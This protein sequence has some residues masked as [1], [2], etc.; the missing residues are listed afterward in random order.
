[1]RSNRNERNVLRSSKPTGGGAVTAGRGVGTLDDQWWTPAGATA[2]HLVHWALQAAEAEFPGRRSAVRTVD[3]HV[4]RPSAPA[5]FTWMAIPIS[6][7]SGH[8]VLTFLFDQG[9]PLAVG[10]VAYGVSLS[11][12]EVAGDLRPPAAL[13]RLAYRPMNHL[14]GAAPPVAHRFEHRPTLDTNGRSPRDG[15]DVVWVTPLDA[16]RLEGRQRLATIVDSWFPPIYMSE[17]RKHLGQQKDLRQPAPMVLSSAHVAFVAADASLSADDS[18]LLATEFTA[19]VNG[20]AF[21]RFEMWN[22]SGELLAIGQVIRRI[23]A[24]G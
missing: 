12:D 2:G 14:Q 3:L 6:V 7:R 11:S 1:M 20:H 9:G 8:D 21:E 23:T 13:P 5:E 16:G 10:T 19:A 24:M 15:W 17:A 18:V 22:E 4:L